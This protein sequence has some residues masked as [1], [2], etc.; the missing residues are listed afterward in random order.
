MVM[1][2]VKKCFL[3]Q[4]LSYYGIL[5]GV[6]VG[7]HKFRC[8]RPALFIEDVEHCLSL[9]HS[10]TFRTSFCSVVG[11]ELCSVLPTLC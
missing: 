10:Y 7:G 11:D 5:Y 8:I 3:Q 1:F 2:H 9:F 6:N 4:V